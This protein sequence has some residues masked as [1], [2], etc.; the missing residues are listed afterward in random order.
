MK[1]AQRPVPTDELPIGFGVMLAKNEA[2]LSRFGQMSEREKRL[3]LFDARHVQTKA[4]MQALVDRLGA[5]G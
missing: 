1:N 5:Q 4:G 2:A 3:V